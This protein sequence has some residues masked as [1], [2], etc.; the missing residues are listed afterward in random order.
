MIRMWIMFTCLKR[1]H[2]NKAPLVWLNMCSHWVKHSPQ[3]YKLLRTYITIFDEYPVENTHSILRAQTKPS[4][5]ADELRNKAKQIFESKEQQATFRSA[6]TSPSQFSFS[7]N[8]LQFLKVKC[9][10]V[11][12]SMLTRIA[13]TPGQSSFSTK[14]NSTTQVKFPTICANNPIKSTALPL[15]YQGKVK[16]DATK[17]CDL[18]ECTVSS[19]N[20][21]W[22][23][24]TGCFHSFHNTCLNGL[25]SCPLM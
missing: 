6:F 8:Q 14:G 1:R 19:Q 23:V 25:N 4:D 3:L 7:Q 15:G 2:Y 16:P 11:L 24:L 10:Q 12:S 20:D 13:T 5:S 18:P 17:Q 9:A 21:D 22:T